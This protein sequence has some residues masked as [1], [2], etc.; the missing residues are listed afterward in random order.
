MMMMIK[1]E[2]LPTVTFILYFRL[3]RIVSLAA[4]VIYNKAL[5]GG[6]TVDPAPALYSFYWVPPTVLDDKS[7]RR[8]HKDDIYGLI[9][10]PR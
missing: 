4:E 1:N 3:S 9:A 6:L 7:Q 5:V 2:N 10:G 8:E